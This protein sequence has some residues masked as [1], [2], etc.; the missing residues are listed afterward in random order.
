MRTGSTT[1]TVTIREVAQR[2]GVSISTASRSLGSGSASAE[3]RR[4]VREAARELG[5]VPNAAARQLSTGRANTVAI[6]VAEQTDFIFNDPFLSM[7]VSQL[8][9]SLS[10]NGLQGFLM[11]ADPTDPSS[12]SNLLRRTGVDGVIVVSF[13]RSRD[14][15]TSI[16]SLTV[17]AMFVGRP[18]DEFSD[19]PYVDVDNFRGGCDAAQRLLDI[20]RESIAEITGPPSMNAVIDRDSGFV[21]VLGR[22]GIKLVSKKS[23][24]FSFENGRRSME[25]ILKQRPQVDAVFAQ[26]DQVAAG[27]MSALFATGKSV[28]QDVAVIGFDDSGMAKATTPPLTTLRQPVGDLAHMA[29]GMMAS[30]LNGENALVTKQVLY[31]PLKVRGTA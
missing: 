17:P 4:K 26:S 10:R 18:P 9:I 16:R 14:L 31:A 27:A 25:A 5:F 15:E 29:A 13:H 8:A 23:G 28:P 19:Y 22:H 2:A 24:K 20:G 1:Q 11:L 3:T 30:I 6:L 7:L 12:F 21:S